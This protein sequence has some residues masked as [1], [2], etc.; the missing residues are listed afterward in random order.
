[1]TNDDVKAIIVRLLRT[2]APE[3]DADAID[4][5]GGLREQA[6]LDSMDFLNLVVALHKALGI[7]IPESDYPRLFTLDG[8]TH[9]LA[10]KVGATPPAP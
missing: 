6:D 4:P 9:Y 10:A 1:M 3:V 2:I 8:A 5:A 7:E